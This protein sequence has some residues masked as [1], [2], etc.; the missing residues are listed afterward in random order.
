MFKEIVDKFE[1]MIE[2]NGVYLISGAIVKE[3]Q[4]KFATVKN[5]YCIVF[6]KGSTIE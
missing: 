2:E 1:S 4:V 6:E 3:S 5:E